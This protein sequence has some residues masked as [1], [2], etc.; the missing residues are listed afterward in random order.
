MIFK[1]R[2]LQLRHIRGSCCTGELSF[3]PS[4]Q[5]LVLSGGRDDKQAEKVLSAGGVAQLARAK[6]C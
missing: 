5:D 6:A 2:F 1:V 4:K 3:L